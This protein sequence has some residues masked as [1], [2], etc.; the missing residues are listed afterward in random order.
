MS[1]QEAAETQMRLEAICDE[2]AQGLGGSFQAAELPDGTWIV[3]IEQDDQAQVGQGYSKSQAMS[4]LIS[5]F[6]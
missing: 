4:D 1:D 6:R 3:S 2:I 5:H